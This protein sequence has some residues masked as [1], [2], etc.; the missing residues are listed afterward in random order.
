MDLKDSERGVTL[1]EMTV[2]MAMAIVI[3]GAAV[4]MLVSV[5]QRQPDLTERGDQVG[6][7]RIGVERFIREIRQGVVGSVKANTTTGFEFETYV[8]TKCGTTSVTTATKCRVVYSCAIEK[9]TRTSG[10]LG[11][12]SSST[13][14]EKLRNTAFFEYVS[15]AA[16]CAS[17]TGEPV[18]FVGV[19]LELRSKKGGV[20]KL[21]DG[22]GLRSCS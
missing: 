2:A 5:L 15:G 9:C 19:A 1:I 8:D 3:T 14:A 22:A 4:A 13:V 10:P 17:V 11:S 12:T 16:P 21:E 7:A 18:T 6:K 20:T